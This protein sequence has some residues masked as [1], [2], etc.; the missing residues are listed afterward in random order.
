M[1]LEKVEKQQ[2][3]R[4]VDQE[5][6]KEAAKEA[7]KEWLDEIFARFGKWS[8]ASLSAMALAA[9]TYF[10]LAMSGWHR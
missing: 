7:I 2:L 9:L 6:I 8:L 5:M 1:T 10:I 4:S 3:A